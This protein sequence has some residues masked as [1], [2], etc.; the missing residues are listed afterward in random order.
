MVSLEQQERTVFL[1][2]QYHDNAEL[3]QRL[4]ESLLQDI[5]ILNLAPK[6]LDDAK[7]YIQDKVTIFR[8]LRECQFDF[9]KAHERLLKTISWRI[10]QG[11][12]DLTMD[13][14]VEFF[15]KGALAF[16]KNTDKCGRPLICVRLRF[17]PREFRDPTKKLVYHIQR[18]ACFMM[19][20]ARKL[21][22]DMTCERQKQGEACVLVSQMTAVVN[23]LKAPI[24]ALDGEIVKTMGIILDGRFPGMVDKVN[25]L[26]ASWYHMGAWTAIKLFLSDEAKNS[27]CFTNPNA[28]KSKIDPDYILQELGGNDRFEWSIDSD[29]ILQKY[30][31]GLQQQQQHGEEEEETQEEELSRSSSVFSD[32][33][34]FD[35][36]DFIQEEQPIAIVPSL[37]SHTSLPGTLHHTSKSYYGNLSSWAG[38][39]MGVDFLT[40]FI[41]TQK[42]GHHQRQ[43]RISAS[44]DNLYQTFPPP[45]TE[46]EASSSVI[47][48]NSTKQQ[49][50][51]EKRIRMY[52]KKIKHRLLKV[53]LGNQRGMMYWVLIYIFLRG[54]V[55]WVVRKSLGRTSLN[56][57]RIPTA[58]MGIT[59]A[60][61]AVLSASLS[62]KVEKYRR[63]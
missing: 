19:E 55:E 36:T 5:Q 26:N 30:G 38:L 29:Q 41:D 40:S 49:E 18:Y 52:Y 4:C 35:A 13:S 24:I 51:E 3:I 1:N 60:M 9:N 39:R 17:F 33:E 20:I 59:A 16:Y 10:E 43:K 45:P 21:M 57:Q 54:P 27:V 42:G 22:W 2:S 8:F 28:L 53:T 11:I 14:C 44:I 34:F 15:E 25:I 37:I 47:V 7:Q 12:A 63:L 23:L 32:D 62:D 56:S 31:F 58:T 6:D 48:V 61:A 46:E 50:T